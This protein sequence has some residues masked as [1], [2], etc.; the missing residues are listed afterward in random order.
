MKRGL[1]KY[2]TLVEALEALPSIGRKSAQ[3]LAMHMLLSDT[4]GALKLAHAIEEAV[5]RVRRCAAC[6]NISEDELC[7]VCADPGRNRELLCVVASPRDILTIEETGS[8]NGLFFVFEK[9]TP[10][11]LEQIRAMASEAREVIFAFSPSIA[12]DAMILYLEE[13]LADLGLSYTR[14]AQGV[15]TGVS[16]ENLDL[17]SVARALEARVKI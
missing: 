7:P 12:T 9:A 17:M 5:V 16:F 15:P 1:E 4:F 11:S 13:R 8:Y 14:I 2:H 3:R 10:E 6:N